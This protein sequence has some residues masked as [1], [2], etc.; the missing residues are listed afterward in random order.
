MIMI[1]MDI[2]TKLF[3]DNNDKYSIKHKY[4]D[5]LKIALIHY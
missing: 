2:I 3:K 4:Y 5:K 1:T